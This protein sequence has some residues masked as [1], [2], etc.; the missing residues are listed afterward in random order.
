LPQFDRV[1]AQFA[2]LTEAARP[3]G[4]KILYEIHTGTLAVSASRAAAL[5]EDLDPARIGAIYDIPNMTRVGIEDPAYGVQVLGPYLAHCHIGGSRPV[6]VSE[7]GPVQKW[8]WEMC[9]VRKAAVDIPDII[10][11]FKKFGY[12]GFLSLE[13]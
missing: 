5:L 12:E 6:V 7:E 1:R 2:A 10:A 9:D 11:C 13:E 8:G 3:F 4:I